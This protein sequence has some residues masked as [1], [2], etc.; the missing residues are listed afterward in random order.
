MSQVTFIDLFAGIGGFHM[1]LENLWARCVFASEI[2]EN[3][4]N[5]YIHNFHKTSPELFHG[6]FNKD[7]N[8]ITDPGKQIPDFNILC[9]WFPCQ[10]FSQAWHK[11]WFEDTRWTLFFKIAEI[12]KTKQPEAFFLENVRWLLNHMNGET[13]S[14]IKNVIENELWYSFYWKLIKASDFGLPQHR[15]RLFMVGFKDKTVEFKFPESKELKLTMD[16]IFEWKCEKKI[17]YTLRCGGRWSGLGDRRNWDSYL[18]NG[19][20]RRLTPKEGKRMQ[21]FPD[22]FEFPVSE[23]QAMKQLGNSVAVPAIQATAEQ[24]ILSLEKSW[25]QNKSKGI[26]ENGVNCMRLW[27][28][29]VTENSLQQ[30]RTSNS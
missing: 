1:A 4:R 14:V 10:P 18:V 12:I 29:F 26:N 11:K 5:T 25:W 20:E 22:S 9:G 3:A 16:D 17:G 21:G 6:N 19:Q 27:K 8:Q 28:S 13:F 2:D 30:I 7:I 24:I 15:P 23:T